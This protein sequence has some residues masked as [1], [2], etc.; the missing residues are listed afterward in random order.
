MKKSLLKH[1]SINL[2]MFAES[3]G[4]QGQKQ[5]PNSQ[6]PPKQK[7]SDEDYEKLKANFDKTSSEIAELKKQL[8]SKQSDEEKKAEE[9]KVKQE[10]FI[11]MQNELKTLKLQKKLTGAFEEAEVNDLSSLLIEGDIDK[12]A[13]KLVA[14][15]NAFKTKIYE[16]AKKE[17][18]KSAT[19]PGGSGDDKDTPEVIKDILAQKKKGGKTNA[20][21][22]YF[23]DNN[24]NKK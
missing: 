7:Y 11:S 15:R 17:F 22:Y 19:L 18:Q 23:G 9:E 13:D 21:D 5:D 20:R 16:E 12:L 1:Y 24:E 3:E 6:I 14:L 4:E 10:E 2:Q 8:K